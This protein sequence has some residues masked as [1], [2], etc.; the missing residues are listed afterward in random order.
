MKF[1]QMIGSPE[2][3]ISL[4]SEKCSWKHSLQTANP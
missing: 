1:T 3:Q 2:E 4:G